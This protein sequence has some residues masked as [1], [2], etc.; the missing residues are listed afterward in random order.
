MGELHRRLIVGHSSAAYIGFALLGTLPI[1]LRLSA[2]LRL[3]PAASRGGV[4]RCI[5]A[6]RVAPTDVVTM[7]GLFE[8]PNWTAYP[9]MLPL[10][11]LLVRS[12]LRMMYG[13]SKTSPLSHNPAYALIRERVQVLVSD[14]RTLGVAM[15]GT[16]LVTIIDK[17]PDV[18]ADRARKRCVSDQLRLELVRD[19]V[20][21]S[22]LAER[23]RDARRDDLRTVRDHHA[24]HRA[25]DQPDSIQRRVS[26]IDLHSQPFSDGFRARPRRSGPAPGSRSPVEHL[27]HATRR[28]RLPRR[29]VAGEP[30]RQRRRE[31]DQSS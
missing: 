22:A 18:I 27:Q 19:D 24:A 1:A 8:R 23:D 9:V 29:A 20:R 4:A 26:A 25:A 5:D 17:Y 21:R 14:G 30:L 16:L 11:L 2:R 7:R 3:R 31:R 28:G 6:G 10:A 15:L 13:E 12:T